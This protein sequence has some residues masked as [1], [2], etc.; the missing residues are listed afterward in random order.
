MTTLLWTRSSSPLSKLIRWGT[1]EPVSH[2]AICLDDRIVFHSNLVGTHLKWK[3]TLLRHCEIALSIPMTFTFDQ[4]EYLY[5]QLIQLDERPYDFM[6][7]LYFFW[8]GLKH[9]L[10]HIPFPTYNS[11]ASRRGLL[12]TEVSGALREL[13]NLPANLDMVTPFHLY[14]YIKK[15]TI[16]APQL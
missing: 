2:F 6:A 9:R 16:E 13:V 14:L 7:L 10:L 15:E 1:H 8:C 4:E 3:K 11:W 12:C 5:Q